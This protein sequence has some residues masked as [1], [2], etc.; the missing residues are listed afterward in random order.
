MGQKVKVAGVQMDVALGRVAENLAQIE[1]KLQETSA[2]GAMLTV[3]PECAVSGYCFDS[4]EEARQFA[5]PVPGPATEHLTKV[6]QRLQTFVV[7]GMLEAEGDRVFNASVLIGPE[8]VVGCYRKVHLPR[9]GVDCFTTPGDRPWQV[10]QCGPM[11]IGMNI[12]Y[13]GSFPE[14]ARCMALDGADLIVLPT[15]WPPGGQSTADYV[16]N[17]RALENQVYYLAVDRVGDERGFHFI[18]KS[19]LAHPN[20]GDVA[21]E[22]H[23]RPAIFY[24][25][26]DL[27]VART[28]RLVR[29]P[30]KHEIDRFRDRRPDLYNRI[31]APVTAH[32]PYADQPTGLHQQLWAP[33]RLEF[34]QPAESAKALPAPSCFI[35]RGNEEQRDQ[36]N[37]IVF[38]GNHTLVILNRYPYSNGHLLVCPMS[39]KADLADLTTEEHLEAMQL[40]TRFTHIMR[41]LMMAYGFYMGFN[42][43][44]VAGAGV[45]G[46]LHWHLVPRWAGDVNFMPVMADVRV[47]PQSLQALWQMLTAALASAGGHEPS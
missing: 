29:V 26:I 5:Q 1:A 16:I 11:K 3:F 27:E 20:G 45:P 13:D 43:G 4:L 42:L 37:L 18:G 30:G 14:A 22:L 23:D 34:L 33:W 28:K 8:G 21:A 25:E 2:A 36:E 19:R 32:P 40:L 24:G 10:Y 41:E 35:C 15:N 17:T 31:I 7:F 39:H 6:C 38:R 9:L 46:H 44:K 47:I 12:C